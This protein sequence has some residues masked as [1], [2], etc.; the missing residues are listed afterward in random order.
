MHLKLEGVRTLALGLVSVNSSIVLEFGLNTSGNSNVFI[1]HI[2]L[3]V[4]MSEIL[5]P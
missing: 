5:P 1:C 2:Q 4:R 3:R